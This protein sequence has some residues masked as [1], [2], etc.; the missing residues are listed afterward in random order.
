MSLHGSRPSTEPNQ[1]QS[2]G[3]TM[4]TWNS[5]RHVDS[6]R[7]LVE[8]YF[9]MAFVP[10]YTLLFNCCSMGPLANDSYSLSQDHHTWQSDAVVW[11]LCQSLK[12]YLRPAT[13]NPGPIVRSF[14]DPCTCFFPQSLL[15]DA[16]G[17]PASRLQRISSWDQMGMGSSLSKA[18]WA[19][20]HP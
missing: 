15:R 8:G 2:R 6:A 17:N 19:D 11:P 9:S 5:D 16:A 4:E 1:D 3:E 7:C 14:T 13:K 20:E 12:T 10:S 18:M